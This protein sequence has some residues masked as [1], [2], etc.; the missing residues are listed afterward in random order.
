MKQYKTEYLTVQIDRET[1]PEQPEY[2]GYIR[3]F[4]HDTDDAQFFLTCFEKSILF[5]CNKYLPEEWDCRLIDIALNQT[6]VLID[7]NKND[8][9]EGLVDVI[10]HIKGIERKFISKAK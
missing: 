2:M 1:F 6:I 8:N 7:M 9:L 4:P 3:I 10:G 5:A